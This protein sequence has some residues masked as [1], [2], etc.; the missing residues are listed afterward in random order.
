MNYLV[1]GKFR[2]LL[3]GARTLVLARNVFVLAATIA[4]NSTPTIGSRHFLF[5]FVVQYNDNKDRGTSI[6]S[7][8]RVRQPGG[9]TSNLPT[10]SL[11]KS[12][13]ST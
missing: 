8:S 10:I 6:S 13:V 7:K 12:Q 11:A 2:S 5:L 1:L 4:T 9:H 3:S